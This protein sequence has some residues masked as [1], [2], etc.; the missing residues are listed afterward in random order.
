LK[1]PFEDVTKWRNLI[2][3]PNTS[4]KEESN[5]K[6]EETGKNAL[7]EGVGMKLDLH[8]IIGYEGVKLN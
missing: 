5:N 2:P 1:R 6:N 8:S 4:F 3:C 7:E